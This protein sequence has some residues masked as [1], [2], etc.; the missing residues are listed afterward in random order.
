LL[1]TLLSEYYPIIILPCADIHDNPLGCLQN[2]FN[3]ISNTKLTYT[4]ST[5]RTI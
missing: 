1:R 2:A 4:I 5:Y 3:D